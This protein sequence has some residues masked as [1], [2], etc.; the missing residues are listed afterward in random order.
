MILFVGAIFR[1]AQLE[2]L[3]REMYPDHADAI[4]DAYRIWQ[5]E[6]EIMTAPRHDAR[7]SMHYYLVA[8]LSNLPGL[9]FNHFTLKIV[10]AFESILTLPLI[11][12]A[13]V[14]VMG[15]R[16]R[17]FGLAVGLMAAGLVAVSYWHVVISRYALRTHLTAPFAAIVIIFLA[18]ALRNNRRG[19]FVACGLA[20]GFS[21]YAY[22]ASR[23]LPLVVVVGVGIALLL[24][25]R[26]WKRRWRYFVNL[27]ALA[28]VSSMIILPM[29]HYA[30]DD[31]EHFWGQIAIHTSGSKSIDEN[32]GTIFS[33][34][35]LALLLNNI[36]N[37]L[38][39]FNWRGDADWIHAVN[40]EPTMDV[41]AGAFLILGVAALAV[42]LVKW[43]DPAHWMLPTAVICMLL[44]S[45]LA[46]YVPWTNPDNTRMN[47]AIPPVYII[48][49]LPVAIIAL[50][51]ARQMPGRLG[52]AAAVIFCSAIL[53]L[54]ARQNWKVYFH[55]FAHGYAKS[56]Q[57]YSELGAT[58]RG[59]ADSDGAYANA[60][61]I[62]WG[63]YRPSAIETGA[64]PVV[65]Q[66][67]FRLHDIPRIMQ[68][69]YSG[70]DPFRFDADIDLL[71][72][73]P[74]GDGDS[75]A[76][77]ADWFPSGRAIDKTA[78]D[79]KA[80]QLYRVP[81]LG[82]AGLREFLEDAL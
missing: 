44:P 76:R 80:Y 57:P 74:S 68:S 45:A 27:G 69:T 77:L 31:P 41:Y 7:E 33:A 20:L 25:R 58:L 54:S 4:F 71:F 56:S 23:I 75:A 24:R 39:S 48:A 37:A 63:L 12:W 55:D 21:A 18:R 60:F 82:E 62:G 59:F 8:L 28:F 17:R 47:G 52:R 1:L 79:G 19:D 46:F 61:V 81:A 65:A 14:E 40:R 16:D 13:G 38:L 78:Y 3:P 29:L 51:L 66:R 73:Y 22:T 6:F 67:T 49:A 15:E 53:V 5:G 9:G 35:N 64:D 43:R 36:R 11:I 70:Q 42:R 34:D 10:A 2:S 30:Q 32:T 72:I 26:S 50:S